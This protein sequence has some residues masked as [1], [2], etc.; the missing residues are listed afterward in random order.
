MWDWEKENVVGIRKSESLTWVTGKKQNWVLIPDLSICITDNYYDLP[1]NQFSMSF[2][3]RGILAVGKPW[4]WKRELALLLSILSLCNQGID[5]AL[6]KSLSSWNPFSH[7]STERVHPQEWLPTLTIYNKITS[8][9][10]PST[11]LIYYVLLYVAAFSGD[12]IHQLLHLN[13][14]TN[15][16]IKGIYYTYCTIHIH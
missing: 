9:L 14:H 10:L 16:L 15:H 1:S 7:L 12:T 13:L 2:K 5:T 11:G 3:I 8:T 4:Q 6:N